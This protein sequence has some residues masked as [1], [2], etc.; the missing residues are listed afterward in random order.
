[1]IEYLLQQDIEK[2]IEGVNCLACLQTRLQ[3]LSDEIRTV[4]VN[5]AKVSVSVRLHV[6]RLSIHTNGMMPNCL[7]PER[8]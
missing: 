3:Y 8:V 2:A 5:N 1:M 4:Y 7:A 6:E